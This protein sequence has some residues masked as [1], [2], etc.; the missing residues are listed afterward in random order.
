MTHLP[1]AGPL[2]GVRVGLSGAVPSRPDWQGRALDRELLRL[3]AAL[4]DGLFRQGAQLVHGTHPSFT[5]VLCGQA[6]A[7][8]AGRS[9]PLLTLVRSRLYPDDDLRRELAGLTARGIVELIETDPVNPNPA[10]ALDPKDDEAIAASLTAM[11]RTLIGGM[12]AL[13]VAGGKPWAAGA[14][15]QGVREELVIALDRALPCFL[16]GGFGGMAADLA[17]DPAYRDRLGNGLGDDDNLYL[18]T[19]DN[20]GGA[21]ATVVAGLRALQLHA[22]SRAAP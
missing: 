22:R 7:H 1:I 16:L 6:Q 8:A 20:Y 2:A 18:A 9:A 17:A 10:R 11:R 5:P 14:R 12:D 13:I 19:T 15:P 4:A 21:T 3:V